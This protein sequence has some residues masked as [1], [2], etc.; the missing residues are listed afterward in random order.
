MKQFDLVVVDFLQRLKLFMLFIF[1][2]AGIGRTGTVIV[3]DVLMHLIE[4]QGKTHSCDL[5]IFFLEHSGSI[6]RYETT[7]FRQSDCGILV[8]A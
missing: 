4:E 2:S 6:S 3:I 7:V 1:C 5:Q 8:N